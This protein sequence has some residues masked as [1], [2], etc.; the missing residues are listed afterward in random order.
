MVDSDIARAQRS[1][2]RS[3]AQNINLNPQ[4]VQR[5]LNG[6][7]AI[8]QG[9]SGGLAGN[10]GTGNNSFK[11]FNSIQDFVSGVRNPAIPGVS[12]NAALQGQS[13]GTPQIPTG[14]NPIQS[15][16]AQLQKLMS[17]QG[18]D[19][20][21]FQPTQMPTF[22]PNKYKSLAESQV[23]AQFNP[24]IQQIMAQ[25]GQT[26]QRAKTNEAAVGNLYSGAVNE[27]NAGSAVQQKG[28]DQS[29]AQSKQ[30]YTDERNRIAAGYAADAAAQRAQAK[31]LG[32]EALGMGT[33]D[34]IAQ[35]NADKQ[36]SD[37]MGSQQMQQSQNALEQQQQ[38]AGQYDKSIANATRAEGIEGQQ[39]IMGQLEQY[40]SQSN[41]DLA[42]TRSQAA[43]S[44]TDLMQKLAGAAYDRDSQN[45]QFQYQQQRDYIGDQQ[46]AQK[47]QQ[48][49]LMAQL[50]AA[51][52]GQSQEQLNPW[53]QVA[54]FAEQVDPG[55][56]ST[57]IA[58]IQK[59]MNERGEIYARGKDEAPMNPALF[60]K[61]VAD[62]P[63]N[64]NLDRNALM[65]VSQVLYKLL[66]GM[67]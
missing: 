53:Q 59:A 8:I 40:M 39:N 7:K 23:N 22:D 2:Q 26:Q 56:G 25:Q 52:S 58:A 47:L 64:S 20:P 54:G 29:Q 67:G 46:N 63:E 33:E 66:Y 13:Y 60:S 24:I 42:N 48:D 6:N 65:Q 19:M 37:Q 45:A 4:D 49:A 31:K 30:L 35:Q 61:L 36:F 3:K 51:S 11:P 32:T 57:L 5:L 28:Y 55:Q 14:S 27:I 18:V 9:M 21:Q 10:K 44:I 34:A 16:L 62:Y 38:S 12:S 41:S 17:G 1:K 50:Q 43:G 15:I